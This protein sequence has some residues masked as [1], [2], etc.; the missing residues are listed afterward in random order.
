MKKKKLQFFENIDIKKRLPLLSWCLYNWASESFPVIITTFIFG[1]YFT[2]HIAVNKITGT[3]QWANAIAL[4][5]III[6]IASPIFGAIADHSGRLKRWLFAFTTLCVISSAL[7]WYAYP[8]PSSIPLTLICIVTGT[9]GFEISLV[10]YNSFL[11]YIAPKGYIGRFS[12]WAWGFGYLGGILALSIALFILIKA[13]GGAIDKVRMCGPL[14]AI[15]FSVFALPLFIFIPDIKPTDR[16]MGN[17]IL[18]G[19]SQFFTTI[20]TIPQQRNLML[21]LLAHLI[22]VDGLNTLFAFAGIYAAGTFGMDLTSVIILGITL[23]IT[24]GIGAILLAWVDDWL[25]AK[26]TI[27]FCLAGLAGFGIP[28]VFVQ[29]TVCFWILAL[30]VA[31]FVGSV[32]AASR[33]LM[34]RLAPIEKTTEMFGLYAFSGKITSFIGPWLLGLT[35]IAFHSQRAGMATI[36]VFFVIGGTLMWFVKE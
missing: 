13:A 30:L 36:L 15:W 29:S 35:T 23:N 2:T 3:Y 21:Y 11:P 20:K 28:V 9:I 31:A 22:Y 10:F 18:K 5:G 26:P 14:V 19:L 16:S 7:L 17:A 34:T 25:G 33:S 27:I 4:A 6:A 8:T 24:A 32:Q 12:G 1:T